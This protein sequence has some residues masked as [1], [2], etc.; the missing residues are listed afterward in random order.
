MSDVKRWDVRDGIGYTPV[1]RASDYDALAAENARLRDA[2]AG[3]HPAIAL[4]AEND[5]LREALT[6]AQAALYGA[7]EVCGSIGNIQHAIDLA[8]TALQ[9]SEL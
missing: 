1:V 2:K 6:E 7:R 8:A 4:L 3:D 9:P 5:K